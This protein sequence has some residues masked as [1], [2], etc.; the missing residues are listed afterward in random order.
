MG[1]SSH[2]VTVEFD[3]VVIRNMLV[4]KR[5]QLSHVVVGLLTIICEIVTKA[6]LFR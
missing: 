5:I 3:L 4:S 2:D 1:I 6:I